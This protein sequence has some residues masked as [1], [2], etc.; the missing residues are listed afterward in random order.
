MHRSEFVGIAVD[1]ILGLVSH[2]GD[3]FSNS[4]HCQTVNWMLL[5]LVENSLVRDTCFPRMF[6]C[7]FQVV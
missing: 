3:T 7:N 2:N 4:V 1:K 5:M 6:S